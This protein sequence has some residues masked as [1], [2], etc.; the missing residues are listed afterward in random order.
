MFKEWV[1]Q[2]E[3]IAFYN[4][5][6]L[7]VLPSLYEGFGIPLLEAMA[8][9]CPALVAN[10]GA[11]PEVGAGA[12]MLVDPLNHDQIASEMRNVLMDEDLLHEQSE[13]GLR[14]ASDFSWE[15]CADETL[16]VFQN[17]GKHSNILSS[18]YST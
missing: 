10:I 12:A 11:L 6:E 15:R 16:Q 18:P 4:L 14:R 5:A 1:P 8:C 3:L 13:K 9:G 7:F 17:V 2:E